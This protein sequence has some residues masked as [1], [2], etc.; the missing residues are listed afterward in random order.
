MRVYYHP[1]ATAHERLEA[2]IASYL[3]SKPEVPPQV[4]ELLAWATDCGPAR[5]VTIREVFS[6]GCV[7]DPAEALGMARAVLLLCGVTPEHGLRL[8]GQPRTDFARLME[9]EF[10]HRNLESP[11][12]YAAPSLL[13]A[14][15]HMGA[16]FARG[17]DRIFE[18][19]TGQPLA[20]HL[21]RAMALLPP[22]LSS[23]ASSG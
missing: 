4:A 16:G 6:S 17:V 19:A 18:A 7:L 9:G 2:L 23:E 11:E 3:R 22:T 15:C 21:R 5:E 20:G 14:Y 12:S 8:T 1:G 13:E 10:H